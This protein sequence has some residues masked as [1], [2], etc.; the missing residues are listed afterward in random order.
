MYTGQTMKEYMK[1]NV[2]FHSRERPRGVGR[3]RAKNEKFNLF[4]YIIVHNVSKRIVAVVISSLQSC[5]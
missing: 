3:P 1:K 2:K 5:P 4:C